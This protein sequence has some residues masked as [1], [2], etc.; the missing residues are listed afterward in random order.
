MNS[1]I[2]NQGNSGNSGSTTGPGRPP[3]PPPPTPS[4][5][6]QSTIQSQY[7]FPHPTARHIFSQSSSPPA[8]SSVQSSGDQRMSCVL[9]N[10]NETATAPAARPP[11]IARGNSD[12]SL[13]LAAKK[14]VSVRHSLELSSPSRRCGSAGP[15]RPNPLSAR[16]IAGSETQ[17]FRPRVYNTT[18]GLVRT[19]PAVHLNYPAV[20]QRTH[21]DHNGSNYR[22]L[23]KAIPS[24]FTSFS[25]VTEK[26]R[27]PLQSSS[28]SSILKAVETE[29]AADIGEPLAAAQQMGS[30]TESIASESVQVY[31]TSPVDESRTVSMHHKQADHST[32]FEDK[33][34]AGPAPPDTDRT[35]SYSN[36]SSGDSRSPLLLNVTPSSS[37]SNPEDDSD[38]D[39]SPRSVIE[40]RSL[41]KSPASPVSPS[42]HPQYQ[43]HHPHFRHHHNRSD[44]H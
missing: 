19:T 41:I 12:L 15:S 34:L 42:L 22:S 10:S 17:L 38:E 29:Q 18:Q 43:H 11:Q 24:S 21:T 14:K 33:V 36:S 16:S 35:T 39:T 32:I 27:Q 37:P 44:H 40:R 6:N 8:G 26:H 1:L 23:P 4:A 20:D 9:A 30:D 28:L 7:K 31:V 5:S 25:T 13:R 3:P 2:Y